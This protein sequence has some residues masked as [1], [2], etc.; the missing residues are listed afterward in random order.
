[1]DL[2]YS[3]TKVTIGMERKPVF[4]NASWGDGNSPKTI[5]PSIFALSKKKSLTVRKALH[6]NAV[7]SP[8]RL[9]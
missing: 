3:L 7:D 6:D 2:F 1:M 8:N 9:L 4:G 5:A